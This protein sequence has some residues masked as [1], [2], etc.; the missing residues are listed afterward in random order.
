M[1]YDLHP[2]FV[3]FPIALLF[4]YSIL[5]IAPLEKFLPKINWAHIRQALLVFGFLGALVALASG[6]TAEHLNKPVRA[7]V[8]MHS[9]FA[10]LATWLYGLL[11]GGEF[12]PVINPLIATKITSLKFILPLTLIL[13][14][15]LSNKWV[16]GILA[17]LALVAILVTGLLGGVM[18]Y[19]TSADPLAP[20]VLNLLGINF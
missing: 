2:I 4:I 15:I 13:E 5:K 19:G 20:I 8:E 7:V 18:V 12:L 14:K 3:H 9:F 16:A 17:V 1:T 6:E 10:A 11:L